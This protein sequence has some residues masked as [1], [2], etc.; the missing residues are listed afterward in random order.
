[1]AI[2][3]RWTRLATKAIALVASIG[4]SIAMVILYAVRNVPVTGDISSALE[5]HPGAYTLSLGHMGDLTLRSFAY[6]RMPLTLACVA[7]LIGAAGCW[8]WSGRHAFFAILV[9]M[10]LFFHASRVALSIDPY[11]SS[12]P[13]AQALLQAPKGQ[14]IVDGAYY[15]FS[16]V[17]FYADRTALL[18]NGRSDN[19]EYGSY[20][21]GAPEYS[22]MRM[23]SWLSG[24]V[25]RGIIC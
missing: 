16:S 1:M 11:L 4:A 17:F 2:D 23:F 14:L 7:L 5:R 24:G 13:L 25:D 21:P 3:N 8:V 18:L 19:L 12:R 10:M 9:M 22:S 6:L 20:A 15:S